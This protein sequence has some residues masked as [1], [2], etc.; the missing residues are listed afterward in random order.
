MH[1]HSMQSISLWPH[2]MARQLALTQ[3]LS[4]YFIKLIESSLEWCIYFG[5]EQAQVRIDMLPRYKAQRL[6]WLPRAHSFHS[7]G[8][9][10]SG[11]RLGHRLARRGGRG[12]SDAAS[13]A[14]AICISSPQKTSV[15]LYAQGSP[16]I[17][18]YDFQRLWQVSSRYCA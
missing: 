7:P 4:T 10:S 6:L 18:N 17:S 16:D 13:R 5:K 9:W 8:L 14:T 11:R 3:L 12:L 2:Q 1:Q 15:V